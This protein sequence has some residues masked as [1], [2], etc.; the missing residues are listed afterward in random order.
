MI[1][2][3]IQAL[4]WSL[5]GL[6]FGWYV[7]HALKEVDEIREAVVQNHGNGRRVGRGGRGGQG[8][9]GGVGGIGPGGGQGGTGGPGG[10]GGEGGSTDSSSKHRETSRD[11][12]RRALGIF[13][14]LLAV[15]IGANV[16]YGTSQDRKATER[17]VELAAR[18]AQRATC[19]AKF[20]EDFARVVR[21]RAKYADQD[22]AAELAM[23]RA[24]LGLTDPAARRVA[25]ENYLTSVERTRD[26]R[27]ANPLPVLED[28]NC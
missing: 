18:E 24:L 1:P 23:W 2:E 27:R 14:M 4:A 9:V 19:Q 12:S 17:Q 28:R 13:M 6:A 8:G 3:L 22:Q 10:S 20:N 25:F 16:W 26:L 21:E 11:R 15:A 7:C 5:F